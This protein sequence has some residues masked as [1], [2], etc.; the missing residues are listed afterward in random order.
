MLKGTDYPGVSIVY[1]CHDGEGSFVLA[2]R[3]K[4]ARDE[5]GRWDI[6]GGGLEFGVTVEE[7]LRKEIKEEY[8]AEILAYE[9][10]GFRDVHR[11][12]DGKPTHWI[13]LDFKVLVPHNEV[14]NAEPHKFDAV[15]WF[16]M[17]NL[18]SPLHSQLGE[19]FGKYRSRL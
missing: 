4:N 15:E 11:K 13:A 5:H 10:L 19:F 14:R 1:F 18:P 6:G 2:K 17:D 3:S 12:H 7:T 8:D 16:R 9:F